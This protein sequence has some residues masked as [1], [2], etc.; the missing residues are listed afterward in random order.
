[1][2]QETGE[3]GTRTTKP[4]WYRLCFKQS[5]MHK[6]IAVIPEP[7]PDTVA[8]G[9]MIRG[10]ISKVRNAVRIKIPTGYQD[11]MGFHMGVKPPEKEIIW[12]SI[13]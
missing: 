2:K 4:G 1:L 7:L 5:V 6:N 10:I 11:E 3:I 12:P 9:S 13:W 8:C